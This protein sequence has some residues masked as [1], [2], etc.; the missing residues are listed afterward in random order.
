[1]ATIL[2]TTFSST[3]KFKFQLKFYWKLFLGSNWQYTSNGWDNGLAPN[4]LQA[5]ISTNDGL[6][7]WCIYI[8]ITHRDHSG[9][10]LCRWEMPLQRYAVS[11]WLSPYPEWSLSSASMSEIIKTLKSQQTP[12]GS[13]ITIWCLVEYIEEN[14]SCH[15]R[16]TLY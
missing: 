14:E 6:V 15:N 5:I 16:T 2:Q 8:H 11:H 12:H 13:H 3:K 4:R 10:G 9:F 1:M 7:Y